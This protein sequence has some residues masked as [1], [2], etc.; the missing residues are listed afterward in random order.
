VSDTGTGLTE[1][2]RT[3]MFDP[4]FTTKT[5]SKGSGLGLSI[6]HG[7]VSQSGGQISAGSSS[8]EG[9][10]F[11]ILLPKVAGTPGTTRR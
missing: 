2:V 4:F 9:A 8:G 5:E 1:Y 7:I 11:E 6:V 10:S 3:H